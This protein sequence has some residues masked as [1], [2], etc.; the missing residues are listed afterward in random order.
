[1]TAGNAQR[2]LPTDAAAAVRE[3][4]KK[5]EREKKS[6]CRRHLV[7]R[8]AAAVDEGACAHT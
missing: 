7:S 3:A 5:R 1:M 4:P 8:W 2:H 6:S